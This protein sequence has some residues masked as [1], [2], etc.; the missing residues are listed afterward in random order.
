ML[1]VPSLIKHLLLP[2]VLL[3]Y[4]YIMPESPPHKEVVLGFGVHLFLVQSSH[5]HTH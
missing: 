4:M 5:F 1:I 3:S 2:T